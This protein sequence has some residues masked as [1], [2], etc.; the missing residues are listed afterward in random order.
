MVDLG[1]LWPAPV[2]LIVPRGRD[3]S[4]TDAVLEEVAQWLKRPLEAAVS[5]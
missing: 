3:G 1:R 5:G 4:S 2:N